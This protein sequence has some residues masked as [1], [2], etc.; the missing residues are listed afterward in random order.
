[1]RREKKE[2]QRREGKAAERA[3]F[4]WQEKE[5]DEGKGKEDEKGRKKEE[6]VLEKGRVCK[7]TE[8]R[9]GKRKARRKAGQGGDSDRKNTGGL[10]D[11]AAT[12]ARG[13]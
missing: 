11:A 7:G 2:W 10:R 1:M 13:H 5:K 6:D 9:G 8:G 4:Y 3:F 12:G